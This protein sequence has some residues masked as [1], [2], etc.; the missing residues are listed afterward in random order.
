[1]RGHLGQQLD[2]VGARHRWVGV[3]EVLADVAEAGG[4]EQ[5]VGAGVGDG[6]GVAVADEAPLARRSCTPPSTS[7]RAGS[8]LNG[9][10]VEALTDP[11]DRHVRAHA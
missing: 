2:A 6:V 3:G 11:H 9:V 1:M 7:T 5:R 8:S 4:A 10:H